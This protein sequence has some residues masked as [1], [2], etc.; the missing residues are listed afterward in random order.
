MADAPA[1]DATSLLVETT[2]A[3]WSH[4][5]RLLLVSFSVGLWR[6]LL[7]PIIV[8]GGATTANVA[9]AEVS[10]N[11]RPLRAQQIRRAPQIESAVQVKTDTVSLRWSYG[12]G[13]FVEFRIFRNLELIRT[14]PNYFPYLGEFPEAEVTD[15]PHGD[16][17]FQVQGVDAAGNVSKRSSPV[18]VPVDTSRLSVP[19][20]VQVTD[21]SDGCVTVGFDAPP[22]HRHHQF[23]VF[24]NGT[25][26]YPGGRVRS[27]DPS[28][29]EYEARY[30]RVVPGRTA[31]I[32][33]QAFKIHEFFEESVRTAPITFFKHYGYAPTGFEVDVDGRTATISWDSP[34]AKTG[35][36]GF[37]L[38]DSGQP[39]AE[40]DATEL[41]VTIQLEPREYRLQLVTV[42]EFGSQ[43]RRS[44]PIIIGSSNV[45]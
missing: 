36:T 38:L 2:S 43:S 34:Q 31:Y 40:T 24:E 14:V 17:Y 7:V 13:S 15:L 5:V 42:N 44:A 8:L 26:V 29:P 41:S 3:R 25:Q 21:Y 4:S 20:N 10:S 18:L 27:D 19:T 28:T 45:T 39:L 1:L 35:T 32:Q 11:A 6:S 23:R 37:V 16:A 12:L 9:A 30:C 22:D 33:V